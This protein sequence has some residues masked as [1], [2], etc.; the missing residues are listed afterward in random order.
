M[1]ILFSVLA[2]SFIIFIH[3]LGHF[4]FAKLFK[5]KVEVF[6]VGIGPSILKFKI[7]STEY[8]LSPIILGGYCKLKGFDHLEKELKANKELEADKD[9]LFGISHFKRILIYFAGPLFNLIFSF[10][11]FIFI[12]M[13]GVIYFDHSSKVSIL[14]KNS[15]LKDKF[16]DGDIILKDNK[17]IEYFSD[18]RNII[19]E[20]KS[21]VTFDVLRGKENITFE[22]TVGLQ[23][24][25]KEIG[26]WIDLVVADVVL[27]S[28]AKIAGMKSGDEIISIDNILL[29]NKRDL[30]DLLKNLNSDVVEIK[31]S[32]NGEIFS[33]KLVF[34]DKSKMIGIYFSPPLKRLIKVENV[35]SAI[36]NSFF[37]VV[38]ALQDILY[39]IFLLITN[40]LNTSKSV[41]GPVGIIGILSSSYSLG[42]LY[43]INNISV[44]SLILAGMNLFFIVIPV[45]D[46]GQIFI[47]FIELLRGKRFKAKTIYS[48]Y[49]FGIFFALFLFGLG[50]FNDLKGLLHILN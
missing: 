45:F 31:F 16:R 1:Y 14:N 20:K 29:K 6:S 40:F 15:F 28:P 35:S 30:D 39:S 48:F 24:F 26:P 8:R 10:I 25:L 42:L 12:S 3:E 44:L 19:P 13:M 38:N 43:W 36:K 37:K 47:S 17:K 5:V 41:S 27:D 21:T 9:S 2:L 34:Q 7:N 4:L 50:L 11:V 22:E 49:S 32:R 46:G 23:D 33:S 18:L